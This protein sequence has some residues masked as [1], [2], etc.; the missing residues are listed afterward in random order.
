M[1]GLQLSG[2][3][4][5]LCCRAPT[6]KNRI[7][8]GRTKTIIEHKAPIE[9]R[10]GCQDELG[11]LISKLSIPAI[12]TDS[13]VLEYVEGKS[14]SRPLPDR[15]AVNLAIHIATTLEAADKKDIIRRDLKPG[16]IMVTDEGSV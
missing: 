9:R 13:L 11:A 2:R 16:N 12:G 5:P 3:P 10:N 4:V 1:A 15:E 6:G 8:K 7:F 14:L